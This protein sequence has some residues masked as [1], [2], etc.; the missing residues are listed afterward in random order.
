MVKVS[1]GVEAK[2]EL[3]G[4]LAAGV[5]AISS[6]QTVEF[7]KYVRVVLPLDGY[8]FWAKADLLSGGALL[9][10]SRANGFALNEPPV[11]VDAAP[12][13]KASGSLHYATDDKQQ[14]DANYAVNRVTFTSKVP[15]NDLNQVGPNVLWIGSF[16][17]VKFAF[18]SRKSFYRQAD[19]YHYVGDAV[20]P[21][22]ESQ[23]VD[24]VSGFPRDLIVSNSL[25]I[26][27]AMSSS[28]PQ[29]WQHF[30]N[31]SIV[32]YPA[33]LSPENVDPPFGTVD[34]PPATSAVAMAPTLSRSLGHSQLVRE[35]VKI[36][37]WGIDNDAA[38]SFVDF[39]NQQSLDF[40][41]FGVM[42]M[43][44]IRDERSTQ[45]ELG[46]LAKKK[47]IE[48]EINYYQSSARAAARKLIT[49]AIPSFYLGN[50]LVA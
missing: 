30:G 13:F 16:S 45:V 22:M 38:M 8:V 46:T 20:Y 31:P 26:W 34:V 19:L 14:A 50:Q 1:E 28:A 9:N 37:L 44:A 17:G 3:G 18:S 2:T 23:L 4:D 12:T 21:I 32:L 33:F 39:V 27:L 6:N 40:D 15:I 43:P 48:Y 42:N 25:P 49:S 11:E 29:A 5:G 24:R 10:A 7:T 35:R 41:L 36:T 47:T